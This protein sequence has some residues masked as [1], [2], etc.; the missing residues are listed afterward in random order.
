MHLSERNFTVARVAQHTK[1]SIGKSER[2]IERELWKAP[3]DPMLEAIA[4]LVTVDR[5]EWCGSPSELASAIGTDMAPNV[6]TRHLNV[7]KSQLLND[8]HINYD[9]VL[10]HEGRRIY[11][12]RVLSDET[13]TPGTV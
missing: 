5:P 13:P 2:H 12:R 3:T 11:L 6:L 1:E 9:R 7:K 10:R 8:Y 4:R